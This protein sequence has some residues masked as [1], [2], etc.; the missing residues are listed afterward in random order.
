MAR[1][2]NVQNANA[3]EG[4]ATA[5]RKRRASGPRKA[6]PIYLLAQ[7]LDAAGEVVPGGSI[8]VITRTN[9]I[10]KFVTAQAA[11]P[12]STLVKIVPEDVAK[13]DAKAE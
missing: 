12:G 6:R 2:E 7:V 3:A 11:N 10:D 8:K 9:D 13:E 1:G 5:T 4:D